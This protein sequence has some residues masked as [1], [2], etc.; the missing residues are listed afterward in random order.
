MVPIQ[1]KIA[2][3]KEILAQCK[4]CGTGNDAGRIE[5]NCAIA[6]A[7]ADIFPKVYVTDL[8]I[9]P[10]GIEGDN[11]KDINIPIPGIAQQFIKLFDGFRF[12]PRLRLMLP[13]FDFMIDIP[14]EVI[15]QINIDDVKPLI[16]KTG[17]GFSKAQSL[18]QYRIAKQ[19]VY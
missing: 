1:F 18:I 17:T 15:E 9:F 10:F 11:K 3:T 19:R 8:Y 5:D 14:D 2:I 13:E 6:I 12:T 7:L 16:E 4:N